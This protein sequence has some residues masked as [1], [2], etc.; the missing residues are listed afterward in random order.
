M[1]G[2]GLILS[3]NR[4]ILNMGRLG[5]GS[6]IMGRLGGSFVYLGPIGLGYGPKVISSIF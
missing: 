5:N 6:L 4:V 3:M 2:M 1:L